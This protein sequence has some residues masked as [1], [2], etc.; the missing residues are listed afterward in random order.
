MAR[1]VQVLQQQ[2]QMMEP[3]DRSIKLGLGDFVFYSVLVAKASEEGFVP[4]ASCFV[5]VLVV[6][7]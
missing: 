3:E 4:W 1:Y 7:L 2:Q 5:V 6:S